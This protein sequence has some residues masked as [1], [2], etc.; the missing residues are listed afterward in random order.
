MHEA[1]ICTQLL[2]AITQVQE[3]DMYTIPESEMYKTSTNKRGIGHPLIQYTGENWSTTGQTEAE[4]NQQNSQPN[5][6]LSS[7]N[8]ESQ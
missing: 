1:D 6:E 4:S 8:C 2:E 3:A 5:I 7:S